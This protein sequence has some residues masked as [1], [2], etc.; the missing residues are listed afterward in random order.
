MSGIATAIIGSAVVGGVVTSNSASK[1]QK[2]ADK[3]SANA[4]AFEQEKYNDWNEVYGPLQDNLA[5]YYNNLTPGYYE[6]V[7]LEAFAQEQ[8]TAMTRIDE[9]LAQRGIDPSSGISA[10][11]KAQ[12]ELGGAEG[13][14]QIR[15]DA[16]RQAA[17]DKRSFL[18]IGL[19]QNPGSTL[20]NELSN[21]ANQ[22][23]VR[24]NQATQAAGTAAGA[25]INTVGTALV[26]YI[27]S[28]APTTPPPQATPAEINSA[29]VGGP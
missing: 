16:P 25:A 8:Q 21:Q 9:S 20:S 1:V 12:S 18:Q 29:L 7:G 22:A 26:D 19:G 15:R 14:A 4:M 2:G 3:R 23:Q 17:E 6:S 13:R 10:S 11:L 27:N 28:P 24:A 5:D